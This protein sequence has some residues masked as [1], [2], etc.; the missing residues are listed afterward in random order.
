MFETFKG[1]LATEFAGRPE[2]ATEENIQ[3]RIRGTLLMACRTSS[4]PSC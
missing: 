4:A 1:A 3:A 2:D